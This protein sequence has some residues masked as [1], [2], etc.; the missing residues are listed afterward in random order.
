MVIS[1][2][3][4]VLTS[5][6]V[7]A[8]T[9]GPAF[10]TVSFGRTQWVTTDSAC[11]PLAG[12]VPLD[13]A[14]QALSAR[15]LFGVGNVIVD[16]TQETGFTC[17]GP[18]ML[19]PGWD[20]L[21]TL[22]DTLGWTFVS[23]STSYRDITQLTPQQQRDESCG[24]LPAFESHGHTR[25][26]VL[27]AY[28]NNRSTVQIQTDVVS[29]CFAFGRKYGAVA[30][31]R[32]TTAAPWFS[33]TVSVN[34]GPCNDSAAACFSI[35]GVPGHYRSPENLAGLVA[36]APDHWLNLQFYRFVSGARG[37][38]TTKGQRWDCTSS[39][40]RR[41]WTSKQEMYCYND[42]LAAMDAVPSTVT[43]ADPATVATAWGRTV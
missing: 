16:R 11:R 18:Y 13:Q 3:S 22:R 35:T 30:N 42:F 31:A 21:A 37:S 41:H 6:A 33:K 12:A 29:T 1:L 24:S 15:G 5:V 7:R 43:P 19:E 38:L 36:V 9:A 27:F 2:Q 28:P 26:W 40:W 4:L 34:G 17:V 39:D 10:L 14:A 23:A 8:A 20:R 25:A 32:A